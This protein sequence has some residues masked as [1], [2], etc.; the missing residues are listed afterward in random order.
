MSHDRNSSG[1]LKPLLP[2]HV[3]WVVPLGMVLVLLIAAYAVGHVTK[4]MEGDDDDSKEACTFDHDHMSGIVLDIAIIQVPNLLTILLN[5]YIYACGL[6]ALNNAPHSVLARQMRKAGGYLAVLII[7]WV[8]NLVYNML[9]IIDTS[10]R[11]YDSLLDLAVLLVSLQGFLNVCVYVWSNNKMRRWF[12]RQIRK[13][14]NACVAKL[15]GKSTSTTASTHSKDR[16]ALFAASK[17]RSNEEDEYSDEDDDVASWLKES[18][19]FSGHLSESVA[20]SVEGGKITSLT[21]NVSPLSHSLTDSRTSNP[22]Y[23]GE[24]SLSRPSSSGKSR[25]TSLSRPTSFGKSILIQQNAA[26]RKSSSGKQ[27]AR[28][29]ELD[30][31][32]FVRFGETSTRMI[33][34]ATTPR[35]SEFAIEDMDHE[36]DD[37][38]L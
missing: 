34:V 25:D 5:I 35:N 10:H 11:S 22:M 30:T 31:E 15:R 24:S 6:A 23:D 26:S 14:S 17:S 18:N 29:S 19:S 36:Q 12:V 20:D 2:F 13:Y 4:V 27:M 37:E 16:H 9:S 32:K 28:S 3:I 33:S 8:P 38:A 21:G 7:V 1:E